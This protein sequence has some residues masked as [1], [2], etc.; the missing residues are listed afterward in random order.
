MALTLMHINAPNCSC[1]WSTSAL[2]GRI[3]V[4]VY[5]RAKTDCVVSSTNALTNL[6]SSIIVE[7]V[8]KH[9]V[10][11]FKKFFLVWR[12]MPSHGGWT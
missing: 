7:L 2:V 9:S 12:P 10:L 5:A 3:Y 8:A 4:R 6:F 1:S 11:N